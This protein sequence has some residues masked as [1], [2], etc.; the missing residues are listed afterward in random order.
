[1]QQTPFLRVSVVLRAGEIEKML[2][3]S[4]RCAYFVIEDSLSLLL[5]AKCAYLTLKSY[6]P[7][8][9]HSAEIDIHTPSDETLSL[10]GT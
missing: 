6:A 9:A 1:M 8:F 10:S 4:S 2:A 7:A 3:F 5:T